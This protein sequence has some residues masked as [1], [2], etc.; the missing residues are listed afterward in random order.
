MPALDLREVIAAPVALVYDVVADVERYPE[1]L[2]DVDAVEKRDDVVAMKVRAGVVPIRMVTRVRFDPPRAIDLDLVDGPFPS[3]RARWTF[4]PTAD[5]AT[6]VAYHAD[7]EL[8]WFGA[9]LG[10][11]S[12]LLLEQQT[13][14]QIRA[15][16]ARVQ[17][18]LP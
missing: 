2:P 14:R 16:Q 7:Y 11:V 9:L 17:A 15:F 13:Q 8:P 6:E 5:G 1:F 3:F 10:G 12:G 18:R 4:T